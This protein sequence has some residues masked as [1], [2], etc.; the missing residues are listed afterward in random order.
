M[1]TPLKPSIVVETDTRRP[2]STTGQYTPDESPV[3]DLPRLGMRELEMLARWMDNVFHIPG[4]QVRF[5]FDAILG[6]IP[7]LGDTVTSL[8]SLFILHEASKRGI[9][10]VTQAR[11]AMNIV[12]DYLVGA[13][14]VVGD[15]FDV[16][17]KAN[18]KN[19]ELLR[20]HTAENPTSQRRMETS[21]WLFLGGVGLIL[22][23]VLAG[24]LTMSYFFIKWIGKYL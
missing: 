22:M 12:I 16:Y 1:K 23:T 14:P 21:D 3:E 11:M 10:R 6:L 20:R 19:L 4:S 9:S 8:V 7:G 24:S 17:W 5:G 2:I 15:I 18:Q 13:I